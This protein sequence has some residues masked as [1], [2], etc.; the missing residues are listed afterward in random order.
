MNR[1]YFVYEPDEYAGVIVAAK[2]NN[3][4][5]MI[6]CGS[7]CCD[8]IESRAKLVN[9]GTYLYDDIDTKTTGIKVVGKGNIETEKRGVLDWNEEFKTLLLEQKRG[10]LFVIDKNG[11]E[12][13]VSK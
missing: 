1:L 5:K 11:D 2:S 8:Y 3:E 10:I 13:E 12:H 9:E 7:I 6:G 4:A